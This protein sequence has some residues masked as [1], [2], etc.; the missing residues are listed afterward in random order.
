MFAKFSNDNR[1]VAYV[2]EFNLYLEDFNSGHITQLTYDGTKSII[3]G[4]FDWAYEEEFG[5]RD[6]FRW[7]PDAS[8]IAFW[9]VDASSIGQFNL[10]NN[11]DSI[12]SQVLP[13]QYPK[14]GQDP[15]SA[16]IGIVDIQDVRTKWIELEGSTV[17]NYVPAIQW[18][19]T[20]ELLI[21]QINRK[22][23]HL[24][25]WKYTLSSDK[26]SLIYEEQEETWV[27]LQY[28]DITS[29]HWGH[30]ELTLV[31]ERESFLRLRE[32]DWRNV[33]KIN[34][35]SGSGT[36][37]SPGNYD[38]A[39]LAGNA[40]GVLYYHASPENSTQRYLYRADLDEGQQSQRLTPE[41]F[42]GINKYD[43]SPDAQYAIH[44]FSSTLNPPTV[45][46]IS[47][48][49]HQIIDTIISNQMYSDQVA[50]L[51][52]PA[53][54]FF[55][56]IT[57][58][59]IEIDGRMIKPDGFDP[60]K[61]YP[62]IF[63]VYGEPWG[64]VATNSW[65][66]LWNIFLAQ[67]GYIVIDIDNRGTPCLKGSAWR[68]SIYRNIGKVNIRDLGQ[69]A[70]QIINFPYIDEEHV[71][72]WGW[73]GGGSSTLQLMFQY[74]DIFHTGV[75]IAFVAY[76]LTYDNIYQERYMGLPQE[77]VDDFIT[78]SPIFHAGNLEGNLLLIHGTADDNVHYQNMEL[79]VNELIRLNKQFD[80]MSYP[81]RTH[82]ISEGTNTT[83]H[84][85]TL[86]YNYFEEHLKK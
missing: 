80:M 42:A 83:R 27:D 72:V 1:F 16:K 33:H 25:V 78:G 76:Q 22:Q 14:V 4:T 47:L 17:Q 61:K 24:K 62:V 7:S 2:M 59:N 12:Y 64:Q 26:I 53:V 9:Q 38:V 79:L 21:Q 36:R 52:L 43:I 13:I 73:S 60:A 63:H 5:C 28:P 29:S 67:Q 8:Q 56:V 55:Q 68:K 58:E 57:E 84:L 39:S 74:P 75:A 46:L 18:I 66:G 85:Y 81:N 6:G 54:E 44:T 49:D 20:N 82:G 37:V 40:G 15:S 31:D 10:I 30:N 23:N 19:G 45:F 51:N 32:D 50:S 41:H 86:M 77:N 70:T 3:N 69:A 48:P 65:I 35:E 11:T 34:L 71:G